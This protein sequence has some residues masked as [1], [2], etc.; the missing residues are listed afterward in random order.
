MLHILKIN[1]MTPF[2]NLLIEQLST[3]TNLRL[4]GKNAEWLDAKLAAACTIR[5][6]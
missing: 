4:L 6:V 3:A 5:G 1:R 2:C